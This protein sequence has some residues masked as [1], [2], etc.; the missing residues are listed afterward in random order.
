MANPNT[1]L[2]IIDAQ[3]N[4]F[5]P[6][7]AVHDADDILEKLKGLVSLARTSGTQVIFVQHSGPVGAVDEPRAPGWLLHPELS[8]EEG[9]L[10]T[11][12]TE[13]S[14]FSNA[15]LAPRLRSKGI[16]KLIIAGMQSELCIASTCQAAVAEGFGVT[17]VADAHTTYDSETESAPE[18]IARVNKELK[19]IA[20]LWRIE[21]I[22]P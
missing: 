21:E 19:E 6:A 8:V 22:H 20:T 5:D 4:M 16:Q 2:L 12:K 17:L 3:V 14:A 15:E 13:F 18:I 9:D 10:I 7:F 1:A 11:Q